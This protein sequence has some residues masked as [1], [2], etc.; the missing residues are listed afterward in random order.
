MLVDLHTHTSCSDGLLNEKDLIDLAKSSNVKLLAITD[1]NYFS[2]RKGLTDYARR[3]GVTLIPGVEYSTKEDLFKA[4]IVGLGIRELHPRLNEY[5]LDYKVQKTTQTEE[6]CL[7]SMAEPLII[8]KKKGR[9][10]SITMET[11]GEGKENKFVY[12]WSEFFHIMP[13][14]YRRIK[15]EH[16]PNMDE[17]DAAGL[18]TGSIRTYHKFKDTFINLKE[19]ERLWPSSKKVNYISTKEAIQLIIESGGIPILAHPKEHKFYEHGIEQLQSWGLQG[20]EVFTHKNR[21]KHD[22]YLEVAN[23]LGLL[24]SGGT[25]FHYPSLRNRLGKFLIREVNEPFPNDEDYMSI[26]RDKVNVIDE[27]I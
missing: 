22:Y 27:L 7:K 12:S 14:I 2:H 13:E 5:S 17:E 8:N 3:L 21:G 23:K 20:L 6:R 19:G 11:L 9:I 1:H 25:D 4:H 15:R 10:M 24:V 16:D 18:M 26:T